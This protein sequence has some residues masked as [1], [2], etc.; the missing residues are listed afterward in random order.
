MAALDLEAL[1]LQYARR[2]LGPS[3]SQR[4]LTL[5]RLALGVALEAP[6]AAARDDSLAPQPSS[7]S[8]SPGNAPLDAGSTGAAGALSAAALS[9][10]ANVG[11]FSLRAMLVGVVAGALVGFGAGVVVTSADAPSAAPSSSTSNIA[12]AQRTDPEK[13]KTAM[14]LAAAPQLG[15]VPSAASLHR[16]PPREGARKQ[17]SEGRGQAAPLTSAS[18]GAAEATFYEELSYVRRAQT[19]LHEGNAM[20]ALGLMRS[21]D[22]IQPSGAL[23]AERNLIQVLALCQLDRTA[24][25]TGIARSLLSGDGTADV[26]RRRLASSCVGASLAEAPAQQQPVKDSVER[27]TNPSNSNPLG[28]QTGFDP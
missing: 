3:T 2:G 24:E 14:E 5:E 13:P 9:A 17:L 8:A 12:L 1:V 28:T 22:E 18:P 10:A 23:W 26:Y 21:L 19:A 11:G 15:P 4:R 20:L 16:A 27:N 7:P 6:P 25:A